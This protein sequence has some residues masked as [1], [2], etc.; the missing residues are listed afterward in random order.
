MSPLLYLTGILTAPFA[1]YLAGGIYAVAAAI[2]LVPDISVSPVSTTAVLKMGATTLRPYAPLRRWISI[3]VVS[4]A[5]SWNGR[6]GLNTD[7]AVATVSA[8][9]S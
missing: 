1:S 4:A 9:T 3:G 5:R 7:N 2:R 8:S 6:P